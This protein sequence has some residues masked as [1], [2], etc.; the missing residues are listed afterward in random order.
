LSAPGAGQRDPAP[1][2]LPPGSEERL[3]RFGAAFERLDA[4]TYSMFAVGEAGDQRIRTAIA[5]ADR[6][7]GRG[8][9]RRAVTRAVESFRDWAAYAYSDRL[10]QTD[11]FLLF[12]S[13]PDRGEDRARFMASLERAVVALILWDQLEEA[14]RETLVG[15]WATVVEGA[16]G[17]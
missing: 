12:Q 10:V 11:T 4:A 9:R 13:L 1:D 7:I 5:A 15:P 2:A 17:P 6:L 3:A 8:P 14:D 16:V